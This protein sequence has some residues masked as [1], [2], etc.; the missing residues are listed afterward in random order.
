MLILPD[1]A[2]TGPDTVCC[3]QDPPVTL[4]PTGT[5]GGSFSGP[6]VAGNQFHP[7]V[8]GAGTHQIRYTVTAQQGAALGPATNSSVLTVKVLPVKTWFAD[9]DKDGYGNPLLNQKSETRGSRLIAWSRVSNAD[10][11]LLVF[12]NTFALAS[13]TA[14]LSGDNSRARRL[15]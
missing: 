14:G 2:F 4:V 13:H 9:Q 15:N 3:V 1:A 6:G 11:I 10:A 5:P 7:A 8:A 12:S